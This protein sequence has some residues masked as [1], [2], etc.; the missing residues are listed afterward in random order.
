MSSVALLSR[1]LF[2]N[3]S[4]QEIENLSLYIVENNKHNLFFN[5]KYN[6]CYGKFLKHFKN[7][8]NIKILSVKTPSFIKQVKYNDIVNSLYNENISDSNYEDIF[9]KKQ[10]A[11]VNIGLFE[12]SVNKN[13]E[14]FIYT[15]IDEAE[16]YRSL[17]GGTIHTLQQIK[18]EDVVE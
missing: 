7:N 12:K 10:I 4:N 6:L 5:K 13:V 16:Y 9:I 17:Y 18:M 2:E 8:K 14:S 15:T 11:N 1:W 3:Y